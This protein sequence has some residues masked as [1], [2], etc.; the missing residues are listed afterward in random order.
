MRRLLVTLVALITLTAACGKKGPPIPPERLRPRPVPGAEARNIAAGIQLVWSAPTRK[1]NNEPFEDLQG[2]E[3][4]RSSGRTRAQCTAPGRPWMRIARVDA[5]EAH[6]DGRFALTDD[7]VQSE[8]WY[9]YRILAVDTDGNR[10]EPGAASIILRTPVP[11]PAPSPAI[12]VGDGFLT[13]GM[14]A[15]PPD[16]MGWHFYR[17]A[18]TGPFDGLPTY[19]AVITTS[20]YTDAGLVND[21]EYR[22]AA[23]WLQRHEGFVVEGPL[24]EP[25]VATPRDLVPPP[26][27]ATVVGVAVKGVVELRWERVDEPDVRYHVYRRSEAELRFRRL[28]EEP[29]EDNAFRENRPKGAWVYGVSSIDVGGNESAMGA[30]AKVIVR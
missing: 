22:Y 7:Q 27:P 25:V 17:K 14:P 3:V 19:P 21:R 26:A 10:S 16:V 2:F 8:H 9:A 4:L 24:S 28:T 11:P 13:L 29:V 5:E 30:Q 1:V 23:T 20:R 15:F 12:E 18:V 6:L